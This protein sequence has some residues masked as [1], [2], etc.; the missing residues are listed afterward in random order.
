VDEILAQMEFMKRNATP[1]NKIR[2]FKAGLNAL[3]RSH[4]D[5]WVV[6]GTHWDDS[7]QEYEF[8]VYA[9]FATQGEAVNW[10]MELSDDE[11]S[12]VTVMSTRVP[13]PGVY[14]I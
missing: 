6:Y 1:P 2:S 3:R 11:R 12:R 8:T 4:P 14:R 5:R 9:E 10:G 13:E 7:R